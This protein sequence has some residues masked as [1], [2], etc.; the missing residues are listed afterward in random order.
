MN[1]E[2][3]KDLVDEIKKGKCILVLGPE[4]SIISPD[5]SDICLSDVLSKELIEELGTDNDF[6]TKNLEIKDFCCTSLF[7][8]YKTN[9]NRLIR[10]VS[11]FYQQYENSPN[12]LFDFLAAL[13]FQLIINATPDTRMTK[14]LKGSGKSPV[15]AYYN[16][17]GGKIDMVDW[18]GNRNDPSNPLVFYLYGSVENDDSLVLTENDLLSYLVAIIKKDP[19]IQKNISSELIDKSNSFLFLGFGFRNWYLRILLYVLLDREKKIER[20]GLS[21]AFEDFS[22][23]PKDKF[24]FISMYFRKEHNIIFTDLTLNNFVEELVKKSKGPFSGKK[25]KQTGIQ[26]KPTVFLCHAEEDKEY[27]TRLYSA[28]ESKNIEPWLDKKNLRGGDRW[29]P[30]IKSTIESIDYFIVLCSKSLNRKIIGYVNKEIFIAKERQLKFRPPI[31]FIIPVKIDND[32][33]ID[34]LKSSQYID[35]NNPE[36]VEKIVENIEYD[37]RLRYAK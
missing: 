24:P 20:E 9:R 33:L 37:Q 3:W 2:D 10:K 15:E 35:I 29:D 16:F 21:F 5:N 12:K 36:E 34:D 18:D 27:A 26:K 28:L 31:R 11:N 23:I 19:P 4:T 7:Y 8:N 13:P 32:E 14:A 6:D 1:E 22:F 30:V 25:A 17:R